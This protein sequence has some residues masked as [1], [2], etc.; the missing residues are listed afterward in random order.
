MPKA[1]ERR[2]GGVVRWRT[3]RLKDG[4]YVHIAIV[5]KA[6]PRGGHTIAG[7]VHKRKRRS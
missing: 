4:R 1:E 3:V 6:G 2:R 7:K 5:P